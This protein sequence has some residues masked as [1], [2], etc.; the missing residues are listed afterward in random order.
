MN[1]SCS[2]SAKQNNFWEKLSRTHY[3]VLQHLYNFVGSLGC[4]TNIF[5][6]FLRGFI[7]V[8][9]SIR[10]SHRYKSNRFDRV[11]DQ[12]CSSIRKSHRCGKDIDSKESSMQTVIDTKLSSILQSN[13]KQKNQ[14]L[15]SLWIYFRIANKR[16]EMNFVDRL[17][18]EM[19]S[20]TQYD[21]PNTFLL[22]HNKF[23]FHC[24][25][26]EYP[27]GICKFHIVKTEICC[28]L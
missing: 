14:L 1:S 15:Y 13:Y 24:V 25:K 7:H 10:Q 26:V 22:F 5:F 21:R 27:E 12:K 18:C 19:K 20:T 16:F 23:C 28:T 2:S 4:C 9:K 3:V 6:S 17:H 8:F 11:I